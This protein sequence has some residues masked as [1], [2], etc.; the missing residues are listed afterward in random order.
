MTYDAYP[1]AYD[2]DLYKVAPSGHLLKM[3]S[4]RDL[5]SSPGAADI[6][7]I[8]K[9]NWIGCHTVN[10]EL[11]VLKYKEFDKLEGPYNYTLDTNFLDM[12]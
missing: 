12:D 7:T 3:P 6:G 1:G 9:G 10:R 8:K 4:E 2:F 11:D 5:F